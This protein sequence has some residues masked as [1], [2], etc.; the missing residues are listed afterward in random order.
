MLLVSY[1]TLA[2]AGFIA[3]RDAVLQGQNAFGTWQLFRDTP[4][5]QRNHKNCHAEAYGARIRLARKNTIKAA[6]RRANDVAAPQRHLR[7]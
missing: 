7:S 1:T 5:L 2:S 3:A 4:F 6:S